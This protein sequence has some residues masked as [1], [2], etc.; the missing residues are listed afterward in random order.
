MTKARDIA[1]AA[2]APSTVSATEIGYL[3]GV[4]SAIQ[5]QIDGKSSTSHNHNSTYVANSLVDAKG[6]LL[7][8]SANDTVSRLAVASTAGYVL[9]VDSAEATGLK[10]AAAAG[11][12]K[13]L[14]VVMASTTTD[15][16]NATTTFA[17]T[18]LTATI[19]PSSTTSKILVLVS[20]NG[21]AGTTACN[22]V[23]LRVMRGATSL[24]TFT[25]AL[26]YSAATSTRNDVAASCSYLDSPSTTSATTY[27][28]QFAQRT[29]DATAARVQITGEASTITLLEIGA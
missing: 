15:T 9:T 27:K 18:T 23:Q 24:L 8:G 21:V 10:W 25:G 2:P 4:S 14:Q 16:S 20:Q 12:G 11:G 29:G 22:G 13:V 6:D 28:T 5:T 26:G 17:D 7:V 1:S 3:D 19:T